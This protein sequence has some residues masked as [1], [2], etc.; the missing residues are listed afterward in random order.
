MKKKVKKSMKGFENSK[1]DVDTNTGRE[2]SRKDKAADLVQM[3]K[4][5]GSK[6][7]RG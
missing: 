5:K 7:K 1:F 2:G 3:K 4:Y 6:G